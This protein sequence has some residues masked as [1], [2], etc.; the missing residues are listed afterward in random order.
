MTTAHDRHG[1]PVAI[2]DHVEGVHFGEHHA[3]EVEE[4][5]EEHGLPYVHGRIAI[6][7]PAGSVGK[8]ERSGTVRAA[9]KTAT[10]VREGAG[11]R[12]RIQS[13]VTKEQQ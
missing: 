7:V 5:S 2:G 1:Q 10:R 11:P 13:T 8:V 3:F 4:L 12:E 6:R 9:G